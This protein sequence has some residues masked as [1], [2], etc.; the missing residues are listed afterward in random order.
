MAND[1]S[2]LPTD[3]LVL[4]LLRLPTSARRR[5]RLV[6]KLWRDAIDE[7]TTEMRSRPNIVA[8]LSQPGGARARVFH[9]EDGRRD[10]K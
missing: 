7:R 1:G 3:V 8:F 2:G 10:D 6:C 9:D 4:I 5:F